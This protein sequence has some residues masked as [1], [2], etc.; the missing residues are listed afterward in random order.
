MF[1][2][3]IKMN[4]KFLDLQINYKKNKEEINN[5]IQNVLNKN[6]YILGDELCV[7]EENFAKYCNVKHC[8]GVGNGTDA[9]EIAIH[10]LNLKE[11][12]E[13]LVPGNT[14][15]ST[16]LGV[17]FNKHKLVLCDCQKDTFQICIDD[18]KKK[19]TKKTKVLL[20]VHL[21]GLI[22]NMDEICNFCE[23]NDIILVEDA[24]QAHGAKW[25]NKRA[26][27]FGKL[28][29]FSFYP[30]KN[31]GAYGDGGAI[32]TND[33]DLNN[34]IRKIRNNG[35]I[36][37]YK[38][39][40]IGRN[41]R[42]DTIQAAI[43]NVKLK[44]LDNNNMLRRNIAN[45]YNTHLPNDVKLPTVLK[46]SLPVYHL[47]VI[48]TKYRDELQDY[49]KDNSVTTL[50]HYPI[51]C[52]ELTALKHIC[53]NTPENCL[54][55]SKQILS[56]PMYPELEKEKVIYVCNLIKNFFYKKSQIT[57]LNSFKTE[58]KGGVLHCLNNIDF[59]IK[60]VFYIDNFNKNDNS[61]GNHANISCNEILIV[62]NGSIK[63]KLTTKN[64]KETI[65]YLNKNDVLH[66]PNMV[67]LEFWSMQNNSSITV[68]CDKKF[69]S[70]IKKSIYDFNTFLNY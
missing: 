61:R 11:D 1:Y 14:Y 67:W 47:Y 37:K 15:I 46:D 43:L 66:I 8:I 38:H 68:L 65:Y 64:K 16:C 58:N 40:I 26:G 33:T 55:L 24:A 32:C 25:K 34:K 57:K 41:S 19:L 9:L 36:I 49:L 5:S 31:L 56:L 3:I 50:I 13:I 42:L 29:C 20:I 54:Q 17:L 51:P 27:S 6:N 10:S 53:N 39:D 70:D 12:S 30:G 28:S 48:K 18:L 62:T 4:V 21:Y 59:D 69:K 35:S 44:Y 7:F 45:I 2:A 60:H 63:I 52:S 22:S 23:E